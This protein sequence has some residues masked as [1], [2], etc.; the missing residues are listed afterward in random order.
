[1]REAGGAHEDRVVRAHLFQDRKRIYRHSDRQRHNYVFR[2]EPRNL[3]ELIANNGLHAGVV[4]PATEGTQW[5]GEEPLAGT[6]RIE[7]TDKSVEEGPMSRV[8]GG[9]AGRCSG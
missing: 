1:M 4:L 3:Q 2:S 7:I 8:P 5:R 9:P 6:L